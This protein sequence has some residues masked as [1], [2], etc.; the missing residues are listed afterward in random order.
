MMKK[1]YLLILLCFSLTMK[2]QTTLTDYSEKGYIKFEQYFKMFP[3]VVD[4][5]IITSFEDGSVYKLYYNENYSINSI[6]HYQSNET[7]VLENFEYAYS[8]N[9]LQL[10]SYTNIQG[11]ICTITYNYSGELLQ[12]LSLSMSTGGTNLIQEEINYTYNDSNFLTESTYI[13]NIAGTR[14]LNSQNN[15]EYIYYANGTLMKIEST[16]TEYLFFENQVYDT[17]THYNTKQYSFFKDTSITNRVFESVLIGNSRFSINNEEVS[18]PTMITHLYNTYRNG[19]T[20]YNNY[21]ESTRHHDIIF[22]NLSYIYRNR[23]DWS[24]LDDIYTNNEKYIYIMEQF[25]PYYI[26]SNNG[27]NVELPGYDEFGRIDTLYLETKDSIVWNTNSLVK[28]YYRY[29]NAYRITN[30]D[31]K[32]IVDFNAPLAQ[33][34]DFISSLNITNI[35]NSSVDYV[36]AITIEDTYIDPDSTDKLIIELNR[37]I[38]AGDNFEIRANPYFLS[39]DSVI[40]PLTIK[41]DATISTTTYENDSE[42]VIRVVNNVLQVFSNQNINS[43]EIYTLNGMLIDKTDHI[44]S[45]IAEIQ[46][47]PTISNFAI[48]SVILEN[49]STESFKII[50]GVQ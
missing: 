36:A 25:N 9:N 31:N 1:I 46:L 11:D 6:V 14:T 8:E 30:I 33:T 16:I 38:F 27:L 3:E 18:E 12:S 45:Q 22:S 32:I 41:A 34:N 26:L 29:P 37:P 19:D 44:D 21:T 48:V 40:L 5:L 20:A 28:Y 4:S 49:G 24:Y 42:T 50:M 43:I 47:K 7:T 17:I 10:I 2:A 15:S 35:A 23:I 39:A 13:K